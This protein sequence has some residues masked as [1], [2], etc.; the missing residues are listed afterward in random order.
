MST[1]ATSC[2]LLSCA[3][4]AMMLAI[5]VWKYRRQPS[6]IQLDGLIAAV[7]AAMPLL[8][9]FYFDYD[10]LLISV[11]AVLFSGMRLRATAQPQ[12]IDRWLTRAW[13]ALYLWLM[14]NSTV[15]RLTHV[16]GTVLILA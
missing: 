3:V 10:L 11:A 1:L 7:I 6:P 13:V 9:P 16:N 12:P 5:A 4:I 8:M 14:V 15:A 2:W